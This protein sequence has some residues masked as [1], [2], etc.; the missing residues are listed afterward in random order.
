MKTVATHSGTFHADDV[1]AVAVL[2]L[3]Y[4]VDVVSVVR[5][6][7]E[8]VIS[9]ADIVVDVGS[10]YDPALQRFDH[11]QNGAPVR[12]NGIPYAAF[13]LVWKEY[14]MQLC[15]NQEIADSIDQ[16]LATP[17]DAGDSGKSIHTPLYDGIAPYELYQVIKSF[18]PAWGS[19]ASKDDAF[20][21]AVTFA[22]E[23]LVRVIAH[24]QAESRMHAYVQEVYAASANKRV[25]QFEQS[26]SAV[27]CMQFPDVELVVTPDETGDWTATAVRISFDS[28]ASRVQFPESWAGLRGE[29][30]VAESG[31]PEMVFCH[32]GRHFIVAKTK[33]AVLRAIELVQ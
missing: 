25:L 22:R 24:K 16:V 10:V 12:E 9:A 13:G 27:S 29:E 21:Q 17:V 20:I 4:G 15:G 23:L 7:D 31:I 3:V 5:T 11:H 19:D 18:L 6:R 32:K 28:F 33:K 8:S 2:Q 14:G 26:V 30:L 1:C